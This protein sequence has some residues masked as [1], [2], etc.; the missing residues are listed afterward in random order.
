MLRFALVMK[1]SETH[2]WRKTG[3]LAT[4]NPDGSMAVLPPMQ[5]MWKNGRRIRL[6]NDDWSQDLQQDLARH[7]E[8]EWGP[9]IHATSLYDERAKQPPP[10]VQRRK[11]VPARTKAEKAA[12]VPGE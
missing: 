12:G 11:R 7:I 2:W 10:E 9:E 4:R 1:L 3:C 6:R 5:Y 8:A